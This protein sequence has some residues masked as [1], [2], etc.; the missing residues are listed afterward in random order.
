[1][2]SNADFL[3][4]QSAGNANSVGLYINQFPETC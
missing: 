1:M 2:K 3:Y 4:K